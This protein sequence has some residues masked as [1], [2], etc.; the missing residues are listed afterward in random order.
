MFRCRINEPVQD[1]DISCLEIT[2]WI[3]QNN[4]VKERIPYEMPRIS[5]EAMQIRMQ[6]VY[7]R[8]KSRRTIRDFSPDPIPEGVLE[9]AILTAGTA[10]NGANL[11]PWHFVVVRDPTV[12]REIRL[13]AEEEERAFY[14]DRAPQEWLD[15]L[16]PLG[17]DAEKPFLETAPAATRAAVSRA[18][19]RPPPR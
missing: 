16:A 8:L 7:K 2:R 17:T 9:Q 15:T 1:S 5:D 3:G 4:S 10:P 18:E 14:S 11:Q 13:A 19:A 6:D 12:K